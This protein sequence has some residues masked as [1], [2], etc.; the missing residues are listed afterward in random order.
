MQFLQVQTDKISHLHVLQMLPRLFDRIEVRRISGKSLD[1]DAAAV[2]ARK[3]FRDQNAAMD[4]RA[5]P[6]HQHAAAKVTHEVFE[7]LDDMHAIERLLPHQAVEPGFASDAAH[8]RQ[9]V[10]CLPLLDDRG[11]ALRRIRSHDARQQIKARFVRKNK[12]FALALSLRFQLWP[13]NFPPSCDFVFVALHSPEHGQLRCPMQAMKQSGNMGFVKRNAEF[14]GDDFG[15]SRGG[16]SLSAKPVGFGTVP[17]EIGNQP[18]LIER[19][20]ARFNLVLVVPSALPCR[21]GVPQR[22]ND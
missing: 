6:Y 8:H 2:F 4:R 19:Q 7:E 22:A 14:L 1:M 16:P 13:D 21:E 3:E 10:A 17:E 11:L 5:I 15:D 18:Q 20:S 12:G 9:M